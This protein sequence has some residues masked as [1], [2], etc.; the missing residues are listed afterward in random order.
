MPHPPHGHHGHHHGPPHQPP[1][2]PPGHHPGPPWPPPHQPPHGPHQQRPRKKSSVGLIIGLVGGGAALL[3]IVLIAV[4]VLNRDTTNRLNDEVELDELAFTVTEFQ[5]STSDPEA[6]A[7]REEADDGPLQSAQPDEVMI[8]T[9][10]VRNL[11]TEP[12]QWDP[13]TDLEVYDGQ[14]ES[15]VREVLPREILEDDPAA[16]EALETGLQP[17]ESVSIRQPF[18]ISPF[19]ITER[20]FRIS[21]GPGEPVWVALSPD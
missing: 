17:D 18:L 1:H 8:V 5:E 16:G 7:L 11:G 15:L 14:S 10:T 13:S 21:D 20:E 12:K 4:L 9:L 6:I 3:A 19:S 2:G